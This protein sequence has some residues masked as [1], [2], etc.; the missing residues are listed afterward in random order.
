M[1]RRRRRIDGGRGVCLR[2][3]NKDYLRI[4]YR[5]FCCIRAPR[6]DIAGSKMQK[7]SPRTFLGVLIA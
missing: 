4:P 1:R 7:E 5:P 2:N 6:V 3:L